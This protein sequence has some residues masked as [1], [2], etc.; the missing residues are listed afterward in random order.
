MKQYEI[1]KFLYLYFNIYKT[2]SQ[3]SLLFLKK[4]IIP[5]IGNIAIKITKQTAVRGEIKKPSNIKVK[6]KQ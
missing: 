2:V 1:E 3:K 5:I 4:Y 6:S